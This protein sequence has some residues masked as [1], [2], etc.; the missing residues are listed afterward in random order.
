MDSTNEKGSHFRLLRE[1]FRALENEAA[2]DKWK[3]PEIER[4]ACT[5]N[6]W[7]I[8]GASAIGSGHR[9][10]GTVRQDAFAL[11]ALGEF[12]VAVV[13]DGLSSASLSHVAS[14]F[15]AQRMAASLV[16]ACE[17]K[18]AHTSWDDLAKSAKA[19]ALELAWL[20]HE[21]SHHQPESQSFY[22]TLLGVVAT[23]DAGILFNIG[24]GAAIAFNRA[25]EETFQP[26]WFLPPE[27]GE[28]SGQVHPLLPDGFQQH[29]RVARFERCDRIIL[30]TDG[31]GE[32]ALDESES[33][34]KKEFIQAFDDVMRAGA[35]DETARSLGEYLNS[36]R[37]NAAS[38]DDKTLVWIQSLP[39]A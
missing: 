20:F 32:F 15:A 7:R 25:N 2:H 30:M 35:A 19:A 21:V 16:A 13:A 18:K 17:S 12:V 23:R 11:H 37:A 27:H 10:D 34:P 14:N 29:F 1:E 38:L 33:G 26:Y 24:D 8:I 5:S 39:D 36:D 28:F 22:T 3:P 6:K 31:V 9:H 4:E